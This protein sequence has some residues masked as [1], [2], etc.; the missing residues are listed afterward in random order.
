MQ[1]EGNLR[2]CEKSSEKLER[3]DRWMKRLQACLIGVSGRGLIG[4]ARDWNFTHLI[5]VL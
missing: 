3:V 1:L 4:A 2:R 5:L